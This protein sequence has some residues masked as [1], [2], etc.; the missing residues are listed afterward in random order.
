MTENRSVKLGFFQKKANGI[1]DT[2]VSKLSIFIINDTSFYHDTIASKVSLE[3]DM[4]HDT[5]VFFL[6]TDSI[7]ASKIIDTL[8]FTYNT[9]LQLISSECGFNKVFTNL[10]LVTYTTNIIDTI[11]KVTTD[12]NSD[13]DINYKIIFRAK[14]K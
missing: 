4:H 14:H 6:K 5:S 9:Q 8:F 11:Q 3:L 10:D 2:T 12:V 1:V 7:P 13:V